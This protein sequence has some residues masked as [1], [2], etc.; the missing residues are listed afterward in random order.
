[1]WQVIDCEI[2]QTRFSGYTDSQWELL[3]AQNVENYGA[4]ILDEKFDTE[5]PGLKCQIPENRRG[6]IREF[7]C[8][9]FRRQKL[10]EK[11]EKTR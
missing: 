6:L 1:M 9:Y 5:S 11:K 4:C 10:P 3:V 2:T 7:R 8:E